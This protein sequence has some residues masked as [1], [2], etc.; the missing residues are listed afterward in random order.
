MHAGNT[1]MLV[2]HAKGEL[3]RPLGGAG[4]SGDVAAWPPPL[5]GCSG[6]SLE[7]GS[8]CV[9]STVMVRGRSASPR[10]AGL[11]LARLR[12]LLHRLVVL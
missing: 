5:Q 10:P 6:S 9:A 4:Q 12:L 2:F 11:A 1:V 8:N 3:Q 7:G